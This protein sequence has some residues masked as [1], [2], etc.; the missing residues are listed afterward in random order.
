MVHFGDT[1]ISATGTDV[2]LSCWFI[3][4][5]VNYT[6]T[7][8]YAG[9]GL[10]W[11]SISIYKST[12]PPTSVYINDTWYDPLSL[13]TWTLGVYNIL[14]PAGNIPVIYNFGISYNATVPVTTYYSLT[15]TARNETDNST[16]NVPMQIDNSAFYWG[17]PFPYITPISV[18]AL[19]GELHTI[20]ALNPNV[21]N[22]QYF[23]E[24][25][26]WSS[27]PV[28]TIWDGTT[29]TVNMTADTDLMADYHWV[30][31]G[32]LI[33]FMFIMGMCGLG[34]LFIGPILGINAIKKKDYQGLIPALII[35]AIGFSLFFAWLWSV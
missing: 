26:N 25:D 22:G 12:P 3:D 13:G 29:L 17:T 34:G 32:P 1:W 20:T 16:L 30:F 8:Y 24:F 33:P 27:L 5:W 9:P 18:V 10:R 11:D 19:A 21:Q 2:Y 4:N 14:T 23:L 7:E 28:N 35:G 6:I 31:M 15:I